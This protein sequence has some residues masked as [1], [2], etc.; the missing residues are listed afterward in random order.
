MLFDLALFDLALLVLLLVLLSSFCHV[1]SC[2][3]LSSVVSFYL[4]LFLNWFPHLFPSNPE[5]LFKKPPFKPLLNYKHCRS[6]LG[7]FFCVFLIRFQKQP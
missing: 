5:Y 1:L 7:V 2:C 3:D 4:H 6:I